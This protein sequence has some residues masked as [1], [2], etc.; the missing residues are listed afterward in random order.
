MI[1]IK[2]NKLSED[3]WVAFDEEHPEDVKAFADT[4]FNAMRMLADVIEGLYE[5]S[6]TKKVN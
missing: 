5:H 4:S 6:K 3:S 1:T 2:I